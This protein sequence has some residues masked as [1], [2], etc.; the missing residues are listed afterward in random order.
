[1]ANTTE[2]LQ[3]GE[4]WKS[5]SE[6]QVKHEN[7]NFASLHVPGLSSLFPKGLA[8][9]ILT[10]I[11]GPRSSG[12]TSVSLHVLAQATACGEVCAVVD[13][14][15][16]FHPESAALSGVRLDRLVWVRCQGNAEHA[17]RAA[18]LLLHAGGFGI[19]LLDLCEADARILNRIPLSY[20]HRFRR[21]VENTPTIL[22]VSGETAQTK[23]CSSIGLELLPKVFHWSGKSPFLLLRRIG[24]EAFLRKISRAYP[25]ALSIYLGA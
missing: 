22:L 6:L 13:L 23:P 1:M 3:D 4:F 8:R 2:A 25:Q 24:T 16:G 15:G 21:A 18:D 7:I 11:T 14:H 19:V 20:W 12:K 10:E 5:A 9:G 17:L